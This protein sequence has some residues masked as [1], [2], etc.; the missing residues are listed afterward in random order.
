MAVPMKRGANVALT[1]E[2]PGLTGLVVGV[3][4]AAGAEQVLLDNLVLATILCDADSRVLSDDHF[5]FFNQLSSPDLSVSAVEEA[6]GPDTEQ[7]EVV[8]DRVPPAVQRIVLVAYLNEGIAGRRT[9]GQLKD[10]TVRVLDLANGN[11]LVRSEN[12]APALGTE[13]AVVLSEVYR[14]GSD[15]K[16]KVIGLGYADGIRAVARDFGVGL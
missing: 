11:E 15:W 5:V 8:L 6:L 12:L 13:T 7:V 2:I 9:L 10:C 3:R 4:F 16:F 1:K 14:H